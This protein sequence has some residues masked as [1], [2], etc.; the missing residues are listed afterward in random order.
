MTKQTLPSSTHRL[1]ETGRYATF[2]TLNP[3]GSPQVSLM[4]LSRT[5]T[6]ALIGRIQVARVSGTGPWAG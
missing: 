4:W 6:T 1:S 3:D 5:E 2:I